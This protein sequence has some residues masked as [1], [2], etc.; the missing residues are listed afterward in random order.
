MDMDFENTGHVS[1]SEYISMIELKTAVLLAASLRMGAT[2]A[3]A[4]PDDLENIYAF[5]I[6]MGLA[7]QIQDD[8]LDSFGNPEKFGKT[9]GGDI[10]ANK[11]TFLLVESIERASRSQKSEIADLLASAKPG[12]VERMIEIYLELEVDRLAEETKRQHMRMAFDK[13]NLIGVPDPGKQNLRA[14][15]NYI[16]EREH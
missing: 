1:L 16:L 2:V 10:L 3:G 8:Y 7:F 12:K 6:H 13:L 15:A 5:G 9:R 14:L 11:K 4:S